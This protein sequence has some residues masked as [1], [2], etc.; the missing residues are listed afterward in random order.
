MET[1]FWWIFDAM[2]IIVG[3]YI[4]YSNAKRGISKVLVMGIGYIIATVAALFISVPASQVVYEKVALQSDLAA[5]Q[6]ANKRVRL[7]ET[8]SRVIDQQQLGFV[9]D[10][11]DMRELL[12]AENNTHFVHSMYQYMNKRYGETAMD[13][14]RFYTIVQEAVVDYYGDILGEELPEYVRLNFVE[15]VNSDPALLEELVPRLFTVSPEEYIE[16]TYSKEP[17]Q[18]M[19]QVF[20]YLILFSIIMVV[21]AIISATLENSIFINVTYFKEHLYGGLV[22]CIEAF[23]VLVM[24]TML[25]RMVVMLGGGELLCFNEPTIHATKIFRFLYD[26]L[27]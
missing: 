9:A 13:E 17:T 8:L 21:T 5:I 4:I 6:R 12:T 7:V 22:G 16:E 3:V 2:I 11:S 10:R 14:E 20:V 1:D 15:K 23:A 26:N 25:I 24:L 18:R 27:S 19:L